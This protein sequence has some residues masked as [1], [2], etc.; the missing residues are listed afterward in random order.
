VG[1]VTLNLQPASAGAQPADWSRARELVLRFG[2]NSMA[3]QILNPGM[4]RWFPADG[5][6][7]VGYVLPGSYRVVAGAPICA[8]ERLDHTAQAFA[9]EARRQGQRV[10][11]FGAQDRLAEVLEASGPFARLP[12]G[13]QPYWNPADWPAIIA[14]KASLR[15]Q[16]ARARNKRV[17]VA[18]WP[19][20]AA[21]DHPAL[22]ICLDQWLRTRGLPPMH[23]L[24]EQATLAVLEDRR[25][26]VAQRE[27][28]VLG[29]LVASPVPLRAGWLIEQVVRG[30]GA[31]NGVAELLLDTAMRELG[32]SGAGFITLGLSPL[33]R[34]APPA[35]GQPSAVRLLLRWVR[36]HGRRFYNF[37]GLDAF[38]A[39]FQPA[40]WEPVYLLS[41]ERHTSLRTL[42]AVAGAF[43]GAPPP[44][45]IA[46]ALGRAA[47]Q[48]LRWAAGAI[49][50][51]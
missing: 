15:A 10:C 48:E 24:V 9:A 8:G 17:A 39:K 40:G 28:Q 33:S 49:A 34:Y 13:A 38:K 22:L 21:S 30:K 31:P 7:V 50:G 11:Y 16:I 19:S 29:F 1:F 32:G 12:L 46:H 3:Y 44:L 25:V 51:A 27:G 20:E 45:F 18:R 36:A 35:A 14:G 6:G 5:Q 37:G 23:F 42:Y 2:W 47:A 26:F 43:A 41:A 4:R